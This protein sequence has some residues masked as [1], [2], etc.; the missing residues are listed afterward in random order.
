M[1]SEFGLTVIAGSER[2]ASERLSEGI[3]EIRRIEWLLTEFSEDSETALVNRNAGER[4]VEVSEEF[5][6]LVQRCLHISE[7]TQGAFDIT[8]AVLKTIY[9][10]RGNAC[11]FPDKTLLREKLQMTGSRK[12]RMMQGQRIL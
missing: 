2:E 4:P 11:S 10:F 8:A 1:G 6:Q 12:I 5:Y 9:S 3:G 7:I